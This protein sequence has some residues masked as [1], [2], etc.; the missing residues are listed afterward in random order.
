MYF[1]SINPTAIPNRNFACISIEHE[2]LYLFK[3]HIESNLIWI[4]SYFSIF[5]ASLLTNPN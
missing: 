1:L 3:F 4:N 2:N 5:E